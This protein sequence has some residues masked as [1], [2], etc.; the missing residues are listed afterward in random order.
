MKWVPFAILAIV[1]IVLQTTI[2]NQV[3]DIGDVYPDWMFILAVHYALHGTWPD[4]AIAA[5]ILGL[6]VDLQSVDPT[7]TGTIGLFAFCYGLAACVILRVR[8]ALFREHFVT[9][10]VVTFV[11]TFCVQFVVWMYFAWRAD[12]KSAGDIA[13]ALTMSLLTA[14]YTGFCAPYLHWVLLRMRR[15]TGLMP[16]EKL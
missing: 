1:T 5:W 7:R 4:A 3:L 12:T 2:V 16:K 10:I 13:S 6:L 15:W 11:M 8:R 9:H 14:A